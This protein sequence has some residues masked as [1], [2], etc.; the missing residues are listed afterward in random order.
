MRYAV[1]QY[2]EDIEETL[3]ISNMISN[4]IYCTTISTFN[5]QGLFNHLPQSN[6]AERALLTVVLGCCV[7]INEWARQTQVPECGS[8]VAANNK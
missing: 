5:Y 3:G 7:L 1:S 4:I 8:Q 6:G 2:A